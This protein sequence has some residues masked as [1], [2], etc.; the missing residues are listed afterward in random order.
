MYVVAPS[1]GLSGFRWVLAIK[2]WE[3]FGDTPLLECRG[4]HGVDGPG[5]SLYP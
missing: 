3:G 5:P 2:A 4:T 1:E